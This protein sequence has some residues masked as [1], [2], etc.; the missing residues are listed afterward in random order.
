M[1]SCS[2]NI[3]WG[4]HFLRYCT[5]AIPW[6]LCTYKWRADLAR[7]WKC[8]CTSGQNPQDSPGYGYSEL[9]CYLLQQG[10]LAL[11]VV[12]KA[13]VLREESSITWTPATSPCCVMHMQRAEPNRSTVFYLPVH[14]LFYIKCSKAPSLSINKDKMI[15]QHE[16]TRSAWGK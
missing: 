1:Q 8:S 16:T 13:W 7:L 2:R 6:L 5:S 15:A 4:C 9:P 12:G 10:I 11:V 3:K 14:Q